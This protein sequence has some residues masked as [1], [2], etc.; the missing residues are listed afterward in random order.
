MGRT[1]SASVTVTTEALL[2]FSCRKSKVLLIDSSLGSFETLK[3]G[4]RL[5]N[6]FQQEVSQRGEEPVHHATRTCCF[7]APIR[8]SSVLKMLRA[9]LATSIAPPAVA[10]G[11]WAAPAVFPPHQPLV[12]RARAFLVL[13]TSL[14]MNTSLP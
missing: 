5:Q 7:A 6:D 3:T 14:N 12:M 8:D 2:A 13:P 11:C 9:W 4:G 10:A 1:A